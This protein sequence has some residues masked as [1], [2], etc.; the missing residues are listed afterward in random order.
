MINYIEQIKTL[1]EVRKNPIMKTEEFHYR[2]LIIVSHALK[3]FKERFLVSHGI[4]LLAIV[5]KHYPKIIEEIN[6]HKKKL[7]NPKNYIDVYIY[8]DVLRDYVGL[9]IRKDR[10]NDNKYVIKTVKILNWHWLFIFGIIFLHKKIKEVLR[11]E[12]EIKKLVKKVHDLELLSDFIAWFNGISVKNPRYSFIHSEIL[13]INEELINENEEE[14]KEFM[15]RIFCP[16]CD[17][18]LE[19]FPFYVYGKNEEEVRK[20][21]I[22]EYNYCPYCRKEIYPAIIF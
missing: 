16:H 11:M 6:K 21:L 1:Y 15:V 2:K 9:T 12:K 18:D 14:E 3:R 4:L 10:F 8:D 17:Q 19:N 22:R 7:E 20:E 13:K 5:I